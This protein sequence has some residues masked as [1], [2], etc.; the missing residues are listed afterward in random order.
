MSNKGRNYDIHCPLRRYGVFNNEIGLGLC[1][2]ERCGWWIRAAE[3]C[4]IKQ[5]GFMAFELTE[6][7]LE[8]IKAVITYDIQEKKECQSG[9][10]LV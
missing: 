8:I 2:K 3:T 7:Y 5:L 4:A 9:M 1:A 10:A 6:E